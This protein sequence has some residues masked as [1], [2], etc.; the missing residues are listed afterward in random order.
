MTQLN[1]DLVIQQKILSNALLRRLQSN[2]LSMNRFSG[3]VLPLEAS[4]SGAD[5]DSMA[6]LLH[7]ASGG[8]PAVLLRL[9]AGIEL[10]SH[11]QQHVTPGTPHL[12][13]LRLR[14]PQSLQ[15]G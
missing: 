8:L 4:D 9:S 7:L 13:L 14:R 15:P 11:L 2:Q 10:R 1:S 6:G 5:S 12:L 3:Q